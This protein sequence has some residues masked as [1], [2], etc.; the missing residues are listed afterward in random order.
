MKITE[1][2]ESLAEKRPLLVNPYYLTDAYL[3]EKLLF[4]DEEM[5]MLVKHSSDFLFHQIPKNVVVHGP[6]GVGKS[7]AMRI[8]VNSFNE[9]GERH[10]INARALYLTVKDLTY[11]KTLFRIAEMMG[12]KTSRGMSLADLHFAIVEYL[13]SSNNYYLIVLDEVDKMHKNARSSREPFDDVIYTTSRINERVGKVAVSMFLITNNPRVVDSLSGPSYSS[14]SPVFIYF[15]D[16]TVDELREILKDRINK[17]FAQGA[18]DE[19]VIAFLAAMIRRESRDLRW[20]F[21]VLRVAPVYEVN[22]KITED[23]IRHAIKAVDKS[24]VDQMLKNLDV[25][26]LLVLYA[27]AASKK[28]SLTSSELFNEYKKAAAKFA[29][30]A[31][32]MKH[33]IHYIT[34]KLE[35]LGLISRHLVSRGRYGR[36]YTF[37]LEEEGPEFEESIKNYLVEKISYFN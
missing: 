33:I 23:S 8:L 1:M 28:K 24:A 4:R 15:R 5:K 26:Y 14:L 17:A 10:G 3:P 6:P 7:N 29:W 36:S 30:R 22:G 31:K 34:P 2:F 25:D 21:Q 9:V 12:V 32:T 37:V 35:T 20:A 11:Y 13:K 16:Y 27:L 19:E 18:V